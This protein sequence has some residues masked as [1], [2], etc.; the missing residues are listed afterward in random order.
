M[1]Q[2]LFIFAALFFLILILVGL[3]AASYVQKEKIP[4]N[5]I[6][7]NRSSYNFGATGTRAFYDLLAETGHKVRRWQEKPAKL[8]DY[9]ANNPTTLIIVGDV[10]REISERDAEDFLHWVS[11]GNT[12]III[13]RQPPK[14]LITTTANWEIYFEKP[15]N[16]PVFSTDPSDQKQMTDKTGAAQPIQPTIFNKN[17]NGVQISPFASRIKLKRFTEQKDA[18]NEEAESDALNA[19]FV[20]LADNKGNILIDAPFG[21]GRIVF[22]TDPYIVA[23]GGI[24]LADNQQLAVNIAASD[25]G[26]IAFDEYHQGYGADDNLILDYFAGT[27][28]TAIFLQIALLVGLIFLA[29]S[30]RF[31]R[32][33]PDDEPNRLSKLEYISAMAE[34]QQRTKAYDLAIENIYKDFRRRAARLVGADNFTISREDL[35]RQIAERTN[36]D[37]NEIDRLMFKCEDIIHGEPTNKN[38]I[39]KLISSLRELEKQLGLQRRKKR[40]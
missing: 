39:V 8:L 12:L 32:A 2:K 28:V 29:Q 4:D 35:A 33:L 30:R 19:P 25:G 18:A 26:I 21:A 31:A 14:S 34:L 38:E 17:I 1:R 40:G 15:E 3:N 5:E 37:F 20:H 22:L 10:R 11:D 9:A 16:F 36:F 24:N 7:P 6:E 27:P 23:N 13:D